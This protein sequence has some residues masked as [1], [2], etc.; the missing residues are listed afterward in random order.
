MKIVH[1]VALAVA[2]LLCVKP[3][4]AV[5]LGGNNPGCAIDLGSV[6]PTTQQELYFFGATQSVVDLKET[7]SQAAVV[8]QGF[9][10]FWSSSS[11]TQ[12]NPATSGT[13]PDWSVEGQGKSGSQQVEIAVGFIQKSNLPAGFSGGAAAFC[14]DGGGGAVCFVGD[15]AS[16][17][18][19][20]AGWNGEAEEVTIYPGG[21]N[22]PF[23]EVAVGTPEA[24]GGGMQA[25]LLDLFWLS[26]TT[27]PAFTNFTAPAVNGGS[28]ALPDVQHGFCWISAASIGPPGTPTPFLMDGQA[29][30]IAQSCS[31][32]NDPKDGVTLQTLEIQCGTGQTCPTVTATCMAL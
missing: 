17:I 22:N 24:Q 19:S 27:L 32:P 4:F 30:G 20:L 10:G 2:L 18:W 1:N 16:N 12:I 21:G 6:G 23:E 15:T 9:A 28:I 14:N 11:F 26:G 5:A 3:A 8:A 13:N 7:Q 29:F 25:T 31:T